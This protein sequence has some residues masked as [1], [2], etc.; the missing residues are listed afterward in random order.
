MGATEKVIFFSTFEELTQEIKLDMDSKDMLSQR[1]AVRFI[2]LN[3]FNEFKRLAKFMADSGVSMLD[4]EDINDVE[5]EDRWI[6]KDMLK[7]A[8]KSC[9]ESTFV[10]PFSELVRFYN[11]DEFRGFLNEII[12]LEDIRHP[13]KRIYIPLIG[14]QN[15]FSDFLSSFARITESAPI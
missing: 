2:M 9:K 13:Q 11:E 5:N 1:Y 3:N 4:I 6:T 8:I 12:L 14:L 7:M 10:T 15:R